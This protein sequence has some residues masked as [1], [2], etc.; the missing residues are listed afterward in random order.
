MNYS[1]NDNILNKKRNSEEQVFQ[2]TCHLLKLGDTK[3]VTD[4]GKVTM[5]VGLYR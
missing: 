5:S 2:E 4:K 1:V 3:Y